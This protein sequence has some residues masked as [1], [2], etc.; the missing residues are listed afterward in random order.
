MYGSS[1]ANVF[2]TPP[3]SDLFVQK[4][5]GT[6]WRFKPSWYVVANNDRT[7]HPELQRFVAQRMGDSVHSVDSGHVAMLSHPDLVIDVIRDA[8]RSFATAGVK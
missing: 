1:L 6:A 2:S 3:S 4:A 8:A 5:E 7:V